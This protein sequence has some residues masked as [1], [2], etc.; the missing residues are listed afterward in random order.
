MF[1][2]GAILS[3]TV[4]TPLLAKVLLAYIIV[5]QPSDIFISWNKVTLLQT[6]GISFEAT[7]VQSVIIHGSEV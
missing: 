7:C 2:H 6:A 1:F 3:I 4:F 5:K